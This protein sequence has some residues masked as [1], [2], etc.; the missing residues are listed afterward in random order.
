MK[1]RVKAKVKAT[2]EII[3][4]I[5]YS[6]FDDY[7]Y[8]EP[9]TKLPWLKSELVFDVTDKDCIYNKGW[10][11][12]WDEAVKSEVSKIHPRLKG[13]DPDYWDRLLHQ[14]AGMAMQGILSNPESELD[15]KGDETLPQ[16][17]AECSVKVATALVNKLKGE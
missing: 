1:A 11:D 14:Y 8:Y 17:L 4:V 15:Y 2:G 3:E 12:G 10:Q 6:G 16:A 9:D 7:D 5:P 13:S